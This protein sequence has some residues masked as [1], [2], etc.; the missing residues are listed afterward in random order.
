MTTNLPS[1]QDRHLRGGC[2][3]G[4]PLRKEKGSRLTTKKVS[5]RKSEGVAQSKFAS[6][7]KQRWTDNG[8]RE[9][10]R[11]KKSLSRSRKKAGCG[12][13]KDRVA[14][15][16]KLP[17]GR[18]KVAAQSRTVSGTREFQWHRSEAIAVTGKERSLPRVER[19][20]PRKEKDA[21]RGEKLIARKNSAPQREFSREK[22][23]FTR[24][25][26][27]P[28]G[29][30]RSPPLT[31]REFGAVKKSARRKETREVSSAQRRQ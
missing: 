17:P 12:R 29:K 10:S 18:S 20:L 7:R 2:R 25:E 19:I 9:L 30:E 4:M 24:P 11:Q 3:E 5:S 26:G 21:A 1:I 16:R 6:T 22:K 15:E 27:A 13:D 23:S 8:K 28:E 14:E 31:E